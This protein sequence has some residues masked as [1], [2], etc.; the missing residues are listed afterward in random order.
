MSVATEPFF[1]DGENL[2]Y[3][4]GR[5]IDIIE[6]SS[7]AKNEMQHF[8]AQA[9]TSADH[10]QDDLVMEL[11]QVAKDGP[12][13]PP[14]RDLT[15][16]MRGGD[17]NNRTPLRRDRLEF[18]V[19]E[20]VMYWSETHKQWMDSVVEKINRDE[21]NTVIS[22]DLD[23]KRAASASRMR[24]PEKPEKPRYAESNRHYLAESGE[25]EVRTQKEYSEP[26]RGIPGPASH[27]MTNADFK[28]PMDA[29]FRIK[30]NVEYWSQTYDQ[31]MPAVVLKI[32]KDQGGVSYDLDVKKG[33]NPMKIRKC[34][35]AQGP[36]MPQ[37]SKANAALSHR[38]QTQALGLGANHG[39]EWSE[40]K[41]QARGNRFV[42]PE[43]RPNNGVTVSGTA[44]EA[45][46]DRTSPSRPSPAST[47]VATAATVPA[48]LAASRSGNTGDKAVSPEVVT[49]PARASITAT[50]GLESQQLATIKQ[51]STYEQN[52]IVGLSS[53]KE[54]GLV[55]DAFHRTTQAVIVS[56]AASNGKLLQAAPTM[57]GLRRGSSNS[58]LSQFPV[59]MNSSYGG[60]QK[61]IISY[62]AALPGSVKREGA[63]IA[64]RREGL[65][66]PLLSVEDLQIGAGIFDP[67]QPHIHAQIVAKL[68]VSGH[69]TVERLAG[70][71]GG[72]NEGVWILTDRQ[73]LKNEQYVLKLISCRRIHPTVPTETE[74]F[75]KLS[76][77]HPG[78]SNDSEVAFP[79]KLF[80]CQNPGP[81]RYDLIVM[82]S[83]PGTRLAEV[84][85]YKW[86]ARQVQDIMKILRCVGA[87][88]K[89]F[90]MR[91]GNT[92]H[93]DLQAANVF[94]DDATEAVTFIDLGGMGLVTIETD[95]EHFKKAFRM[96]TER[97]GAIKEDGCRMFDIGYNECR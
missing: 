78:L 46:R 25:L 45:G 51:E 87:C 4:A 92:Q 41:P 7:F 36:P 66:Q 28:E 84:L 82:Q 20:K 56:A 22:Y 19:G 21:N 60:V 23:V 18:H 43:V 24:T 68:G 88:L 52:P 14:F 58:A 77:D 86:Q 15:S 49:P 76:L 91:Y 34:P 67:K 12:M 55:S 27:N 72:R 71:T 64:T 94:W 59:Q 62:D 54:P 61:Q 81:R 2:G 44:A 96:I 6:N 35:A 42:A 1:V 50:S 85:S 30:Q 3:S 83:A 74:N 75:Q 73:G 16:M 95:N 9:G 13:S 33:A 69:S 37:T 8:V 79:L 53:K 93:A 29:Q 17:A 63:V 40:V 11:R 38:P 10:P 5:Y 97:W 48:S 89:R 57:T 26:E 47:A 65:R 80:A 32:R 39:E 90:H 70:F 31:W